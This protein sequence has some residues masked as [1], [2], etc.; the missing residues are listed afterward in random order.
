VRTGT[1]SSFTQ[2]V[3]VLADDIG[4]DIEDAIDIQSHEKLTQMQCEVALA[5]LPQWHDVIA[6]RAADLQHGMDGA[7]VRSNSLQCQRNIQ[8]VI[9]SCQG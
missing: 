6:E 4:A 8:C 9:A 2:E 3:V 1:V 5:H 7:P